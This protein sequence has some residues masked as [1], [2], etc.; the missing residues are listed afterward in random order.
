MVAVVRSLN[1]LAITPSVLWAHASAAAAP[2]DLWLSWHFEPAVVLSLLMLGCSYEA[3]V[4]RIR[5]E[6]GARRI[7][8]PWRARV[9]DAGLATIALALLSPLDD[10]SD[11]LFSAHMVQH[12][13]LI[14]VAPAL[15]VLGA[16]WLVMFWALPRRGR[17]RAGRWW[18]RAPRLR[19]LTHFISGPV[20]VWVLN[21]FALCFWHAPGPYTAALRHPL[22]HALEHASFFG[23]ALLFWWVVLQPTGRRVLSEPGTVLY[24]TAM[25]MPMSLLGALLTFA[26]A[27]WYSVHEATTAA[28]GM[29]A[30]ADQQL[31]GLIM[32]I[33]AGFVYLAVAAVYF[34]RWMEPEAVGYG[35]RRSVV[36]T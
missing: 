26:P 18:M 36:Q 22:V 19:G 14:L 13:L 20:A 5:R 1:E 2:H 9:F 10:L 8:S 4:R 29:T 32:W 30:L 33:P 21:V 7:V 6:V 12:M 24:V 3:G 23:T 34:I 28:F 15:C 31:A 25:G 35:D 17:V 11:A 16:P 27:P